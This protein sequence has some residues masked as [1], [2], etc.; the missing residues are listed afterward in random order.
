MRFEADGVNEGVVPAGTY[1]V[2]EVPT[3][4][5]TTTT[6]GCTGI[7]I[8]SPQP[9]IPVC[10]I[11]NTATTP[12]QYPLGTS[13]KCMDRTAFFADGT[14]SAT[15]GYYNPNP[16]TVTV[17]PGPANNVSPGGPY[18]GQPTIFLA[19]TVPPAFTIADIPEGRSVTWTL[20][21]A[22]PASSS[23]TARA[24]FATKC[25][26]NPQPTPPDLS[27]FV[28]CV[29]NGATTYDATFGYRN[30]EADPISIPVGP[31]NRFD[32][33]PLDRNQPAEFVPGTVSDAVTVRGIANGTSLTWT[34]LPGNASRTRSTIA[35]ASP[36]SRPSAVPSL[37][38]RPILPIRRI[39]R[40][41]P[42][43]R[44]PAPIP[45]RSASSS[46]A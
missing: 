30:S 46:D 21:N 4:G 19:G 10:T 31:Q 28:T 26:P 33:E 35:E 41:R 9:Q 18:H 5:F 14:F 20:A 8:A 44:L 16:V 3:E 38:T 2:T 32:P 36:G 39:H 17:E 15:F 25:A 42:T 12:A 34:I 13:L 7:V 40:F 22:P 29:V 24:D 45:T 43:R 6:S 37:R 11:T 27:I 23:T 1:T